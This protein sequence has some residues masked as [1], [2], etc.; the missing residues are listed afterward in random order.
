M[1]DV[2][3]VDFGGTAGEGQRRI[4][5]VAFA[6]GQLSVPELRAVIANYGVDYIVVSELGAAGEPVRRLPNAELM[7]ESSGYSVYKISAAT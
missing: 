7:S 2:S 1:A 4:D 3:P 6:N 5:V